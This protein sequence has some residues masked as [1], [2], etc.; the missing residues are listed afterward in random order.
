MAAAL[1]R[2][3]RGGCCLWLRDQVTG[4][5]RLEV[6]TVVS[7]V[8]GA[9][10]EEMNNGKASCLVVAAV[11]ALQSMGRVVGSS[12]RCR[13]TFLAG[14]GDHRR[15][16]PSSLPAANCQAHRIRCASSYCDWLER[17]QLES[18]Y[19]SKYS[20]MTYNPPTRQLNLP[21]LVES[22]AGI[23]LP[24]S[25]SSFL[26]TRRNHSCLWC[27][28]V[29]GIVSCPVYPDC[30]LA[31][32]LAVLGVLS[33]F[34]FVPLSSFRRLLPCPPHNKDV[35]PLPLMPKAKLAAYTHII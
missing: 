5:E 14:G 1:W 9:G 19:I 35:K 21:K 17:P 34:A 4:E 12:G 11:D 32:H 7:I 2:R 23:S 25:P 33:Y 22:S 27:V 6:G 29:L 8:S 3:R 18:T 10:V 26:L 24:L 20:H 31:S 13:C 16:A 28:V 15:V 30:A